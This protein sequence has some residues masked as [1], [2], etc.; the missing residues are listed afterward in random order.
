[1]SKEWS[2]Y[3]SGGAVLNAS[4][5]FLSDRLERMDVEPRAQSLLPIT[6]SRPRR[7]QF[8]HSLS[9]SLTGDQLGGGEGGD[10][11]AVDEPFKL[12]WR[13][14]SLGILKARRS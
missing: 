10:K 5:S 9:Y 11:G 1:M 7:N 8:R 13:D 14:K 6:R 12:L 3:T 2:L 4:L